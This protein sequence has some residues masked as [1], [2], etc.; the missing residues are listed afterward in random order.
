D[1]GRGDRYGYC[2]RPSWGTDH[3]AR[4]DRARGSDHSRTEGH[5]AVSED[6]DWIC[7]RARVAV[8]ALPS[9]I[10][11]IGERGRALDQKHNTLNASQRHRLLITCKHIDELLG[12]IE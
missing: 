1:A 11:Q 5:I 3:S 9:V 8:R 4:R 12:G 10:G 6:D 7:F 2:R